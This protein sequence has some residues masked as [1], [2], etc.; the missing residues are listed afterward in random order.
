[1]TL[2]PASDSI[3]SVTAGFNGFSISVH[4]GLQK[5]LSSKVLAFV[6]QVS[7][8][9]AHCQLLLQRDEAENPMQGVL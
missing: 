6:K 9:E 3:T 7:V 2:S 8:A 4:Q 1:M 5:Q